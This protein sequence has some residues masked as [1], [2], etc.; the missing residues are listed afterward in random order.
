MSPYNLAVGHAAAIAF[1]ATAVGLVVRGRWRL[2]WAFAAYVPVVLS[3]NVVTGLWPQHFFVDGFSM[4]KQ[5]AYDVL[6]LG[7][8]LELGW[9]TFHLFPGAESAARK[10]ALVILTVTALSALAVP[11]LSWGDDFVLTAL[12]LIHPRVINGTIWL[13]AATL[14]IA[15]WYRVPVHPFHAA[16]LTSFAVYLALFSTLLSL[17]GRYGRALESFL[18]VVDPLA[19]VLLVCWWVYIVWRPE[20]ETATAHL[21]TLRKLQFRASSCG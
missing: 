3:C 19:Y 17:V 18:N 13:M 1:L 5:A 14:V 4:G 16:V 8:A 9:R 21:G 12:G 6:K 2:S 11:T 7:I 20:S 10:I 15:Q